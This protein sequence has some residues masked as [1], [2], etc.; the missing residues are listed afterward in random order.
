MVINGKIVS[1]VCVFLCLSYIFGFEVV[2]CEYY[3]FTYCA[4]SSKIPNSFTIMKMI[5]TV[6]GCKKSA[7]GGLKR[8]THVWTVY[9]VSYLCDS[10]TQM[11]DIK[12]W[13]ILVCILFFSV[14]CDHNMHKM[15]KTYIPNRN[16]QNEDVFR[17]GKAAK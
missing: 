13:W 11:Y 17:K 14:S 15:L 6:S 12:N 16:M 5:V 3:W 4:M 2:M 9:Y 1:F 7:C 8:R 10:R